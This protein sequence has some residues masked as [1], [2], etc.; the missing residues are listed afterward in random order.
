MI[1][2]RETLNIAVAHEM[3]VRAYN[4]TEQAAKVAAEIVDRRSRLVGYR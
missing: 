1:D 3:D 2:P 4:D